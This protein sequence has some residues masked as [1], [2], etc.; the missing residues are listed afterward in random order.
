MKKPIVVFAAL[1]ALGFSCW[2]NISGSWETHLTLIPPPPALEYTKLS[3][4]YE[5]TNNWT[6]TSHS[7]FTEQGFVDQALGMYGMLGPIDVEG[8][9]YFNPAHS[10]T[11]EVTFPEECDVQ[12]SSATLEAPAYMRAE[13]EASLSFMGAE[14]IAGFTHY[15]YPYAPDYLWPCCPPQTESYT[16][17][18]LTGQTEKMS[19]TGWF[20]DCCLGLAFE[21]ALLTFSDLSLCCGI[22]HDIELSF[23]KSGFDYILVRTESLTPLFWGITFDAWVKFTVDS[24]VVS[25]TPRFVGFAELCVTL[26][27]D[28]LWEPDEFR[29]Y[30][31][32]IH[33]W[34]LRSNLGRCSY[35]EFLTAL[36]VE[37]VVAQ[38]D[39]QIFHEDE[40]E[41]VKLG[42]C[43]PSCCGE[44]LELDATVFFQPE[45]S[46]F[47]V[48]RIVLNA[49][50][51]VMANL[52]ILGS[53]TLDAIEADHTLSVGWRF[54]F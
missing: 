44:Q 36:D 7:V 46:L 31:I 50:V 30:G 41:Y 5:I 9:I 18:H 10:E 26:F 21:K 15:A 51:P 54:T 27:A 20:A 12:T 29:F 22:T 25:V 52:S 40:F 34:K 37:A 28:V 6:L 24:K 4:E 38:L 13:A 43:M 32:Q 23:S 8:S 2:G 19:I 14:F 48:T 47:G 53:M 45:G 1:C 39:E 33:G 11:V 17:F 3:L 35:V 42:F 49:H 16:R